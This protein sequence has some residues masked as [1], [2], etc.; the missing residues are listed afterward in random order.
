MAIFTRTVWIAGFMLLPLMAHASYI[1]STI[2]TA[3]VN[4]ATASF[5]NPAALVQLKS[6]Q[7]VAQGTLTYFRTQFSG[8]STFVATG[9]TES[10]STSSNTRFY[11]PSIYLGVPVNNNIIVGLAIV[12]NSANRNA[13]DN[14]V[15]R[16]VQSNN[17]IQDCDIVPAVAIK[18]NQFFSIGAGV[19]FSY[20]N[21][22][23][24]PISGFPGS[25]IADS[26]SNN[27]SD[28]TGQGANAGF[29]FR[30]SP[31]TIIGF[32]YR[33]QTA[34]PLSGKS[35]YNGN[36]KVVSTN[37]HFKSWSPARS[38]LS[39]NHFIKPE[40]GFI[41]TVQRIQW[42]AFTNVH[43]YGVANAIGTVPVILNG[44]IPFYLRDTW[45]VTLGSHYRATP[46][47]IWRFAGTYSQSPGNPN[48]EI[49]TGDSF[50][51]GA[52][53]GYEINKTITIDG[54]YA[55]AFIKNENI[56]VS[57]GRYAINGVNEGSRDSVSLKLTINM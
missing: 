13:D 2:G 14:S 47:W 22:N 49:T 31:A 51:L 52:S 48:Y 27:Q 17:N 28:G 40:L 41:G 56:N 11:S 46:K 4:D 3:V 35:V 44:S 1:E 54:S 36:P 25:N 19:N 21:L 26:Q 50:V 18:L 5:F 20:A 24:Q 39:V 55:H 34:Y 37:Y 10:G 9:T 29:L 8:Q 42:S 12:T 53:T 7:V 45:L 6:S 43:A 30:P 38:V 57:G 16:Y 32:N 23:L 33:S 15:L